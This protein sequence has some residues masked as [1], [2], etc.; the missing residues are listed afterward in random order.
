MLLDAFTMDSKYNQTINSKATWRDRTGLIFIN[1][2][3]GLV[4]MRCVHKIDVNP[5]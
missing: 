5:M 3:K 4:R 2:W 1:L